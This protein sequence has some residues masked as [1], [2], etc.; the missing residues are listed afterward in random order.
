MFRMWLMTFAGKPRD[1]HVYEHAHE[2]PWTMTLPL[3]I[4]AM[5][6]VGVA[7]GWP[8]YDATKS[9]LEH[10]LH[11]AQPS[12][13]LAD[14]GHV[15][16]EHESWPAA[17]AS[18][19][20]RTER[21]FAHEY[22]TVAGLLALGLVVMGILF[23]L[24]IYSYRVLDPAEAKEQF[25]R[26][27]AFLVNKWYFDNLYSVL[28]V[29]PTMIVARAFRA[30]DL[31]CIDGVIHAVARCTVG[32]SRVTG[33]FDNGFIDYLV[34]LVGRTAYRLGT[35]TPGVQTGYLRSYVLFLVLAA[36]GLFGMLAY[37]A[38]VAAAGG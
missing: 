32:V 3:I 21:Y 33:V 5:L 25:P 36:I 37:F 30:F 9:Q 17:A 2:S 13:V 1:E 6:S 23:A 22:H 34:N 38:A 7:W 18:L 12:A 19:R 15:E 20:H 16:K 4:L 11:H 24:L 31:K 35:W 8:L 14:F 10:H 26:I 29:R 27:Y 28:L